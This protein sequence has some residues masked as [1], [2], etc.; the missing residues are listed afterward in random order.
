MDT[1]ASTA[2]YVLKFVNQTNRSVFLTGKAGTGKTTLLRK[3]LETTHKNVVVVAP[4][5]IAALNAG[6]VTVHSMFQLPFGG[7][8]PD[9]IFQNDFSNNIKFENKNTLGRHF[10]MNGVKKAVIQNMELLIIDE[11][12]MLRPDVLDAMDFMMQ[13]VR[14]KKVPFGG[15]Q[16]LF[17]GD[18][19]QLPPVIKDEEWNVLRKYYGGKFFFHSQVVQQNPPLYLELSKIFRQDDNTFIDL[20][21]SL[22]NNTI[23]V[24][25]RDTLNK[26]VQLDFDP[27]KNEGYIML[28][29]HNHKV[30]AINKE[31]LS[32]LVGTEITLR[33]DVVDDFPDKIF[34]IEADLKLKK[35]AQVMFV[36]NDTSADKNFF[37]GKM[38]LIKSVSKN[39]VLVEFPEEKKV[40]EVERFEWK[41]IRYSVNETSKEIEEEVL[42]TF[43]QFPLKLAW[44]ITV[45]KSQGLTFDKAAIDVSQ[46][47][48]PGQ[49]YVALSRLRSLNGLILLSPLTMNGFSND[50]EVMQYAENKCSEEKLAHELQLDT[51]HFLYKSLT[52]TFEWENLLQEWRNHLFSYKNDESRSTQSLHAVWAKKQYDA[53][54]KIVP[55]AQKFISQLHSI[56]RQPKVDLDFLQERFTAAYNYF[57]PVLDQMVYDLLFKMEEVVRLKKAK[58]FYTELLELENAQIK[59]VLSLMKA[60]KLIIVVLSGQLM[61]KDNLTSYEIKTYKGTILQ[62]VKEDF[63]DQRGTLV[64]DNVDENRYTS[65]KKE[66]K[67]LKK[68]T[69]EETHEMWLENNSIEAIAIARKLTKQTISGHIAKLI[70]AGKIDIKDVLPSLLLEKLEQAFYG[71]SEE[72]LNPLKEKYGSEFSWDELK[73]FKAN[74]N[75]V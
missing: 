74:L 44:A 3:I 48:M 73:M 20:L 43:T 65:T 35:G 12:S 69:F 61:D 75:R 49:A 10:R 24:E 56:F 58:G 15:I 40:I 14:K 18:L 22:R 33:A 17:I 5:G 39:E 45:H 37:N 54:D 42:G 2:D 68:N 9:K 51:Q 28:T 8:I 1:I 7:F 16:V 19:L 55:L 30:D 36:K 32:E 31:A 23:S 50:K 60:Q 13:T 67:I 34:P 11:V 27:K 6:G 71:Y 47:F 46:V 29:T 70:E 57:M 25:Q 59:T 62:A 4:T 64:E 53:L 63:K 52:T 66:K 72:S 21:D 38:G 26:Y 41:N